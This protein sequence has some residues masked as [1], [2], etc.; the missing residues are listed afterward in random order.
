MLLEV[1]GLHAGYRGVTVVRDLNLAVDEGQIVA[2]LGPNGAGKSTTLLTIAGYLPPIAG[3]MTLLGSSMNRQPAYRLARKGVATINEDRGLMGSLT[4]HES[5]ALV[6]HPRRNPYE[7]FPE[8]ERLKNRR[9][10]LLS[11]G[12]QQMLALARAFSSEPKL[13]LVDELSQ[14]LAPLVVARLL[15][16]LSQAKEDWGAAVIL[17]EQNVSDALRVA[18]RGYVLSHGRVVIDNRP[19]DELANDRALLESSYLGAVATGLEA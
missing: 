7:L 8:L 2:L 6:R 19:A 4:V 3:S 5:L 16:A 12:E 14:G 10:G 17:V 15:S 9:S 1:E 18:D 11:G 13:L